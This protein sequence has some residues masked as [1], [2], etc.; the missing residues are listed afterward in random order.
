MPC[1]A[2]IDFATKA[3][4]ADVNNQVAVAIELYQKAI[5]ELEQAAKTAEKAEAAEMVAKAAEYRARVGVLQQKAQMDKMAAMASGR[6]STAPPGGGGGGMGRIFVFF[7]LFFFKC[8]PS[9]SKAS[10]LLQKV[11]LTHHT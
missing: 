9:P 4:E 10:N 7:F 5:F 1:Q 3:I 11:P 6:G 8:C 2:A